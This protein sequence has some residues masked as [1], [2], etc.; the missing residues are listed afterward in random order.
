VA[1]ISV[2]VVVARVLVVVQGLEILD[3]LAQLATEAQEL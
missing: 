1:E 3:L 2:E